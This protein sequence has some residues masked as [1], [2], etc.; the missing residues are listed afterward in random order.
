[1]SPQ[2]IIPNDPKLLPALRD[3]LAQQLSYQECGAGEV[4]KGL[5]CLRYI[6]YRP[7]EDAV[8]VAL[9]ALRIEGEVLP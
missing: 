1:M 8:E 4:A 9:E 2:R 6:N 5:F 3:L 7:H